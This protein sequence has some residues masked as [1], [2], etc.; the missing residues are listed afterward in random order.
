M[1]DHTWEDYVEPAVGAAEWVLERLFDTFQSLTDN[2]VE[3]HGEFEIA[4]DEIRNLITELQTIC[5]DCL[6]RR[7]GNVD[8]GDD[9][10]DGDDDFRRNLIEAAAKVDVPQIMKEVGLKDVGG[11]HYNEGVYTGTQDD[12]FTSRRH[13]IGDYLDGRESWEDVLRR[14]DNRISECVVKE[15]EPA[16][17]RIQ[18]REYTFLYYNPRCSLMSK[19]LLLHESRRDVEGQALSLEVEWLG[20]HNSSTP[21]LITI[22]ALGG[23]MGIVAAVNC[24]LFSQVIKVLEALPAVIDR[25]TIQELL[26][27]AKK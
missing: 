13:D 27:E 23:E 5:N 18:G 2:E 7:E 17:F 24:A 3:E 26:H 8:D 9:G 11:V 20:L 21:G 4:A 14:V 6:D 15:K 12:S 10:D 16:P 25:K 19:Q 1:A 22:R